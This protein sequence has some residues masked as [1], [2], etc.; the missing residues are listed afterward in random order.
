MNSNLIPILMEVIKTG[1]PYFH[2]GGACYLSSGGENAYTVCA[3]GSAVQPA[4][5]STSTS[6]SSAVQPGNIRCH[7]EEMQH[8]YLNSVVT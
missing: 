2:C 3:A 5:G 1:I 7:L 6:S 4:L 8:G